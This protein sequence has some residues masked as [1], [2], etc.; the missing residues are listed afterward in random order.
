MIMLINLKMNSNGTQSTNGYH[1]SKEGFKGLGLLQLIE[2][3]YNQMFS[4]CIVFVELPNIIDVAH[5]CG[6]SQH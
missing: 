4:S 1:L 6:I 5:L 2:S 3:G